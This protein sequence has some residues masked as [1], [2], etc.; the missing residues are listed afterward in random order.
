M[1]P[2]E[3]TRELRHLAI[4]VGLLWL[5]VVL[6]SL[7]AYTFDFDAANYS[8][9]VQHFDIA[10]DQ[11]HPP[12]YPLWIA[13]AKIVTVFVRDARIA[14]TL[15]AALFGMGALVFFFLVAKRLFGGWGAL[16][17]TS[18]L[19]F[20][21][22]VLLY[23]SVQDTYTVDL[24]ASCFLAWLVTSVLDGQASRLPLAYASAAVLAGFRQSGVVFLAPLLL[25]ATVVAVRRK[26]WR[27]LGGGVLLAMVGGAIW[28][29][30]TVMMTNFARLR[31]HSQE[32]FLSGAKY[33]SLLYGASPVVYWKMVETAAVQLALALFP[34]LL[35]CVLWRITGSGRRGKTEASSTPLEWDR[36][37]FY[38]LWAAPCLLFDFLIHYPKPG[39]LLLCLPP[40]LLAIV[41]LMRQS[42]ARFPSLVGGVALSL[43]LAYGRPPA[44]SAR[45]WSDFVEE[46]ERGTPE[47]SSLV[48]K[49]HEELQN[50]LGSPSDDTLVFIV[51][52]PSDEAPNHRTLSVDFPQERVV[53]VFNNRPMLATG[54]LMRPLGNLSSRLKTIYWIT[55]P[56]DIPLEVRQILPQTIQVLS[57]SLFALWRTDLGPDPLD[58]TLTVS[59]VPVHLYR[60]TNS[61]LISPTLL[62]SMPRISLAHGFGDVEGNGSFD[63][64]WAMGPEA[65]V[66]VKFPDGFTDPLQIVF[67]VLDTMRGVTG[68]VAVNGKPDQSFQSFFPLQVIRVAVPRDVNP[69]TVT[70][71][72]DRWN[73]HPTTLAPQDSR[74]M[75]VMFESIRG[76]AGGNTFEILQR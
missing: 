26:L 35:L 59:G 22:P 60:V 20:S 24:F 37:Y 61:A 39:Y 53:E 47:F 13:A 75:A 32:Q 51:R 1:T 38:L 45:P 48:E 65:S 4:V 43:F 56:N 58:E 5:A 7:R 74:P 52:S 76:E 54:S 57:N 19:A 16:T 63:W 27:E 68:R 23:S 34:A 62:K 36:W 9:G 42:I 10:N 44:V 18:L 33:T 70:F 6:G 46:A 21:S 3:S 50:V 64:V 30:P 12:G 49:G 31:L 8:L 41:K 55:R 14:L 2:G 69:A 66:S 72:F 15:L 11:P 67:Q 29:V 40:L 73:G 71:E 17:A 25:I 28:L